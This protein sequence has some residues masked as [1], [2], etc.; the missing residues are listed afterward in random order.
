MPSRKC[1]RVLDALEHQEGEPADDADARGAA[2]AAARRGRRG[3]RGGSSATVRLLVMRMSVLTGADDDVVVRRPPRRSRR[4]TWRG[5]RRR[6]RRGR[7]RAAARW[8]GRPT[9]RGARRAP[10]CSRS[11]NCSAR[12]GARM[13]LLLG[14]R[15]SRRGRDRYAAGLAKLCVGG[16]ERSSHSK[17]REPQGFAAGALAAAQRDEEVHQRERA[18]PRGGTRRRSRGR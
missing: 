1:S 11:S 6:A 5:R 15:R 17:L 14:E 8:R 9:S 4:G 3:P 2:P 18:R 16:G 10:A 7:R 13:G 12:R